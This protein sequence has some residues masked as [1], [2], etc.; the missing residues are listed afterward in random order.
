MRLLFTA[1]DRIVSQFDEDVTAGRDVQ[2]VVSIRTRGIDGA[3][4]HWQHVRTFSGAEALEEFY[5]DARAAVSLWD[6]DATHVRHPSVEMG[7]V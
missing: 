7:E 2:V 6:L 5:E 1:F 3:Q 4:D